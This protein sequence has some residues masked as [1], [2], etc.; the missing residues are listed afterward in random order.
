M[1]RE[2]RVT[3]AQAGLRLDQVL[4]ALEPSLSRRAIKRAI[5]EGR[6]FLDGK[7]TKVSSRSVVAGARLVVHPAR[8]EA[9]PSVPILFE[10]EDLVVVNKPPGLHVNETESTARPSIEGLL[11]RTRPAV[12][13]VHRLDLETSGVLVLAKRLEV[14]R[15][16]TE[17][18]AERRVEKCYLAITERRVET[19]LVDRPIGPDPRSPRTRRA[20]PTGKP[21]RTWFE[22]LGASESLHLVLARPETGRTH[23]IRVHLA[24]LGAPILGDRAYGG[25]LAVR[26]GGEIL[27]VPR[28]L[29]HAARLALP[30]PAESRRWEAPVPEDFRGF[31]EPALAVWAEAR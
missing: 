7:R 13:V 17:A 15:A 30:G 26:R 11:A 28:V 29:L 6:V 12:F 31:A 10:D 3:E 16:L 20:L 2:H 25:A 9:A 24:E 21:A 19:G 5:E 22:T 14:A 18:F 27:E 1:R 4:A 8:E 23:Q